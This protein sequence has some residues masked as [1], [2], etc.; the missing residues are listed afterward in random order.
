MLKCEWFYSQGNIIK[1]TIWY[2]HILSW[3]V[4]IEMTTSSADKYMEQLELLYFISTTTFE[5]FFTVSAKDKNMC[6]P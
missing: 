2:H 3:V 5:K 4:K 6:T 1:I